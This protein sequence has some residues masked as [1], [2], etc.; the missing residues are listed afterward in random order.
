MLYWLLLLL[1]F[2]SCREEWNRRPANM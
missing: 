2:I 1:L